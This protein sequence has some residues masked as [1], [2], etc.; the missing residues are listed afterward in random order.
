PAGVPSIETPWCV[1]RAGHGV[2]ETPW[3]VAR[4]GRG[5]V[6]TK[7]DAL[8][9]EGGTTT[10]RWPSSR[11]RE[12]PGLERETEAISEITLMNEATYV[13]TAVTR[14]ARNG[15]RLR[16]AGGTAGR[17]PRRRGSGLLSFESLERRD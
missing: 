1:A 17:R 9:S 14:D 2:A 4:A 3:R 15:G 16:A 12:G 7:R 5:V 11:R 8:G 10:A 13:M 6:I